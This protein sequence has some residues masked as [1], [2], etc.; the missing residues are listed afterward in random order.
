MAM[1]TC[2]ECGHQISTTAASCPSCGAMPK[3]TS[4]K[5]RTGLAVFAALG[6]GLVALIVVRTVFT[7]NGN[8]SAGIPSALAFM[9][10]AAAGWFRVM[11]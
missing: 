10:G 4:S 2:R 7:I 6:F 1:T 8:E 3:T 5:A 11:R 9:A